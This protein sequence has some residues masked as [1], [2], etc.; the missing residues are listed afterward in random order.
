MNH[1]IAVTK[2][3]SAWNKTIKVNFK[4]FFKS[5]GKVVGHGYTKN[6]G[7]SISSGIDA[8]S[9]IELGNDYGGIAWLLIFRSL[10]Q[11]AA[12]LV[13]ENEELLLRDSS[14]P[15]VIQYKRGTPPDDPEAFT[16]LLEVSLE[17]M[18]LTIDEHFFNY[19]E[20]LPILEYLKTPFSQWLEAFGLS[21][22]QAAS[23]ADHLPGY[24]VYALNE[25]WR[26]Q[27][28]E[29]ALL[30]KAFDT[31]FTRAGAKEQAWSQYSAWLRKQVDEP[32]FGEAFSL[33]QVYVPLRGYYE[34]KIEGAK[35]ERGSDQSKRVKKIVV[36]LEQALTAWVHKADP[37]DYLRVISGGPGYGK[38]SFTKMFASRISG[39]SAL[40]VLF[41]PLHLIDPSDDLI[42][43][44]GNYVSMGQILPHNPLDSEE[45]EARLLIIFDGLDELTMQGKLAAETAQ[46]FV[47]EVQRKAELLNSKKNPKLRVIIS[48]RDLAVQANA[49]VLRKPQQIL[50]VL[51]YYIP[52]GT[53]REEYVDRPNLL[54]EDQRQQWWKLYGEATGKAYPGMPSELNRDDFVEVTSQPLLNYLVALSYERKVLNLA[55]ESNLNRIYEDLLK[56]VYDRKWAENPHPATAEVQ[57]DDFIRILEEVAISAWH[58][59]GRKTTVKEIEEHCDEGGLK[60]LLDALQE[61]ASKG[62]TR[63]LMAFYFRQA[64]SRAGGSERTFEFTHKSFGEY[65]TARRIVD[66]VREIHDELKRPQ[67]YRG[68]RF[69]EQLALER[70]IALCGPVAMDEYIF[71]FI[72]NEMLLIDKNIVEGWQDTLVGLVNYMLRHGMPMERMN[73]RPSYL[74][75]TQK[76]RNAE[77]S[78]LA[79]MNACATAIQ[80]V[81]VIE[82]PSKTSCGEWLLSLQ[83]QRSGATNVLAL[84]CLSFL[85]L[86]ECYFDMHD[87]YNANL[88][89]SVFLQS[90]FD[91]AHLQHADLSGAELSGVHLASAF[92]EGVSLEKA[93][94]RDAV[95]VKVKAKRAR[96]DKATLEGALLHQ[97]DLMEANFTEANIQNADLTQTDLRGAILRNA[98]LT[99]ADL[100]NADLEG[101]DL[102]GAIG[103]KHA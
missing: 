80:K 100:T 50:H 65:L 10:L 96:F 31:P 13:E 94:L 59:D 83:G 64:G 77:E 16:L 98:D 2:P 93:N 46:Q 82:W 92:L 11:A 9:A 67:R 33:R 17:K 79:V 75:E 51:P 53:R 39:G 66:V 6:A 73:P 103:L 55:E 23:I 97:S 54:G 25:Q 76:S 84:E 19:P 18:Q 3:I 26:E 40:R 45:G 43:A 52:L 88:K 8:A 57:E 62:V 41:V 34:E 38:S 35:S 32:M 48:G 5:L 14:N 12:T 74:E 85:D 81:S 1:G 90:T 87:F 15:R 37:A 30:Q 72:S 61:G 99:D 22:P 89:C 28:D 69:N 20:N 60:N 70:W 91:W 78:L 4:E 86:S 24:F 63:L 101:A 49:G 68:A 36:E 42:E 56:A 44:V 102:E 95:L 7:R 21:A 71:K 27:A 47:A 29:Y 58:G